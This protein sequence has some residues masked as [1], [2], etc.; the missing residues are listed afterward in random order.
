MHPSSDTTA[1]SHFDTKLTSGVYT[2][3]LWLVSLCLFSTL[4][5]TRTCGDAAI[6]NTTAFILI[7]FQLIL[8]C[9]FCKTKKNKKD[10]TRPSSSRQGTWDMRWKFGVQGSFTHSLSHAHTPMGVR[11][12]CGNKV[13]SGATVPAG[14][15]AARTEL[16]PQTPGAHET[17]QEN[18][19]SMFKT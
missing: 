7:S 8:S 9:D 2:R 12:R 10:I 17:A 3:V 13:E 19:R 11:L 16:W 15:K 1:L 18:D 14:F 4:N 5:Y 6:N